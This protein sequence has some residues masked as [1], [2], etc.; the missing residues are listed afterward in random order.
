MLFGLLSR[1]VSFTPETDIPSLEGKVVL[2]TGGSLL[3]LS[4]EYTT[5]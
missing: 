5:F 4:F 2:V 1:G 3:C